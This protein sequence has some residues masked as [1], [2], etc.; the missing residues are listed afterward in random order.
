MKT[1]IAER[2]FHGAEGYNCAQAI[3][4]TFQQ[5]FNV[6]EYAILDASLN[7]GGR[8]EGG[9]CGALH[10]AHQLIGD[11]NFQ[12]KID[13]DFIAK[14]GSVLC[15]EIRRDKVMGCKECV[16]LAAECVQETLKI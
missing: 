6:D 3:L 7:G 14:G 1:K 8:A 10:A 4:K 13:S 9:R 12:Q 5:E 11:K 15:R 2:L 16:I